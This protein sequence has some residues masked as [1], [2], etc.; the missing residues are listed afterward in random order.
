[1]LL[2]MLLL[3]LAHELGFSPALKLPLLLPV[4]PTPGEISVL[5]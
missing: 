2:R 4:G 3:A 5:H 1:M